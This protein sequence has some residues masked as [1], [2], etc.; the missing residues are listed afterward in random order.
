[1]LFA[2]PIQLP[3]ILDIAKPTLRVRY[4]YRD[5][6]EP[7]LAEALERRLGELPK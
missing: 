1:M 4:E 5:H 2:T 3:R 7:T 6:G